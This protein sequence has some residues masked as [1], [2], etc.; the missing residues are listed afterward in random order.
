MV[1]SIIF[2]L[3]LFI[4]FL[5]YKHIHFPFTICRLKIYFVLMQKNEWQLENKLKQKD[6]EMANVEGIIY[7]LHIVG[8]VTPN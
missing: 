8:T 3:F 2:V 6:D 7:M 5:N 4:F 1:L